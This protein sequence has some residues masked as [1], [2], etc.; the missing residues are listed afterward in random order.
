M[1]DIVGQVA[2]ITG[3]ARGI[4]RGIVLEL[5]RAGVDVVIG[6]LLGV[7]EIAADAA[8]TIVFNQYKSGQVAYS[9]V[10]TAQTSAYQA[11][12]AVTQIAAQ[13]QTTAVALIQALGGGWKAG[14][15][16]KVAP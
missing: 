10:V 9:S 12:R 11:R 13:R 1:A 3:G 7:P 8:E 14:A 16:P 15:D 5:A 4:G 2:I 6:D